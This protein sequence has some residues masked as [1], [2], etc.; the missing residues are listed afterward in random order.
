MGRNAAS[1][2]AWDLQN[3]RSEGTLPTAPSSITFKDVSFWGDSTRKRAE[4]EYLP[5]PLNTQS[6]CL[7][8]ESA[9]IWAGEAGLLA[10]KALYFLPQPCLLNN[11][12]K[13]ELASWA[14]GLERE[15]PGQASPRYHPLYH[16][17]ASP[18]LWGRASL[19]SLKLQFFQWSCIDV[20]VGP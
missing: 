10:K 20:R 6:G 9:H 1:Q 19:W 11:Q 14:G 2:V 12:G 4:L 3:N 5:L 13:A 18:E 16:S 8:R 17:H 7:L 15:F